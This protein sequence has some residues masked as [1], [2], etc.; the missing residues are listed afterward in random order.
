M[1]VAMRFAKIGGTMY[2]A[3]RDSLRRESMTFKI[4]GV[5]GDKVP[6]GWVVVS[7]G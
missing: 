5:G 2:D 7:L 3:M 1:Q 6:R 4:G